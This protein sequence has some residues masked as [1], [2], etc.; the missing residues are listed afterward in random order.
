MDLKNEDALLDHLRAAI[1]NDTLRLPTLPEVAL[2]VRQAINSGRASDA[3]LARLIAADPALSVRLLQVANSP[4]Y[5][6]PRKIDSVQ[7]ALTRLGH[8]TIRTL[9]MSLAMKQIFQPDSPLLGKY[10][11]DIWQHSVN[12]AAV[13]RALALRCRHLNA[14]QAMLGGLI[15]QIGKLPL[16]TLADL[17]PE[18]GRDQD[19][20]ERHLENLHPRIGRII[21]EAWEFPETLAR[22]TWEYKDLQRDAGPAA[23]YVDVVQVAYLEN[24]AV[25]NAAA[26]P[27]LSEVRSFAKLG[28]DP[29]TE[30]MEI[31]DMA[32]EVS[33]TSALI[34]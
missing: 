29:E 34:R 19:T 4:M 15:H 24:L 16:L 6:A 1:D 3:E 30:I 5:R 12:V 31:E 32:G 10:F 2:N 7:A 27:D 28:L 20:L 25:S 26:L 17:F 14:D 18:L 33:E 11:R 22:V 13:A 21:M 8:N 23:D 9:V